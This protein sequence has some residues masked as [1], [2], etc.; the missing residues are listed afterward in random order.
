VADDAQ[1]QGEV[2][3]VTGG[4][5]FLGRAIVRELQKSARPGFQP[6]RE[7]RVFDTAPLDPEPFGLRK[8][9][10]LVSLVGDIRSA[11]DVRAACRGADAVIHAASLVDWGHA[12]EQ[13]LHD[14]NVGG[15][16]NVID[17][18]RAQGVGA[19]VYTS[20]M[21]VVY[22][23]RPIRD[24]DETLPYPERFADGYAQSKA[25]AEQSVLAAD[26]SELPTCVV[27][28]CGMWGEADPYHV[29]QTLRI[30]RAGKLS[31]RMGNGEARFQ[32]VYVGNVAHAHL[33]AMQS[34]L[35]P[36]CLASGEVYIITD[37]PAENFFDFLDPILTGLGHPMPPKS[38]Y[39]PFPVAWSI[40]A[41]LEITAKLL[42]PFGSW[43]PNMTR[44]SVQIVCQDFT[45]T[46]EKARR[47]LG[48]APIYSKREALERTIRHFSR[49]GP[50]A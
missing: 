49:Y 34:L 45:F 43:R 14:I 37:E 16:R 1:R 11:S 9:E 8:G 26:G 36:D 46:G 10:G 23:R 39:I 38:K 2:V 12:T 6:P 20:T 35:G 48:Y 19:L 28:P 21:D 30:A 41:V 15:T 32:H 44:S 17:A 3:L 13:V 31:H 47:Q 29:S 18:C 50:N 7:I 40:G 27:R 42:R 25:L 22:P 4:A 24:G 33:L 5:G